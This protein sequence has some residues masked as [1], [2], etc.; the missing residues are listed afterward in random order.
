MVSGGSSYEMG[1]EMSKQIGHRYFALIA[2]HNPTEASVLNQVARVKHRPSLK[3][4]GCQ[5]RCDAVTEGHD[6]FNVV[7]PNVSRT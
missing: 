7:W 3:P 1:T 6:N 5:G 2:A 4:F